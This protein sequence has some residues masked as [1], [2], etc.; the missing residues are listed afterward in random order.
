MADLTVYY[1]L[2]GSIKSSKIENA[3]QTVTN[4]LSDNEGVIV[5]EYLLEDGSLIPENRL[6]A[7]RNDLL[8]KMK[9]AG[10]YLNELRY[11]AIDPFSPGAVDLCGFD[12]SGADFSD[13]DFTGKILRNCSFSGASMPAEYQDEVGRLLVL[14]QVLYCDP[15]TV[16]WY[17]NQF[18]GE[19][20]S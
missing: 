19:E 13:F 14:S 4:P 5:T 18:I 9:G 10:A 1:L 11:Y 12:L 20:M 3:F 6:F 15:L 7:S 8:F 2:G 17:N 16:Q